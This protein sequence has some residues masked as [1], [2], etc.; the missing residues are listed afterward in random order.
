MDFRYL[1]SILLCTMRAV[2]RACIDVAAAVCV[3]QIGLN[4]NTICFRRGHA[5]YI[6]TTLCSDMLCL[7][8]YN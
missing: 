4:R 1:L 6:G 7:P 5:A 8:Q 3:K 2:K